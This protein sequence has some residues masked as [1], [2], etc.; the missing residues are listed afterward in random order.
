MQNPAPSGN[1]IKFRMPLRTS[2]CITGVAISC[3][4]LCFEIPM[5]VV[6]RV[7]N[8]KSQHLL[9]ACIPKFVVR[10]FFEMT[11]WLNLMT[12]SIWSRVFVRTMP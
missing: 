5:P 1:V 7:A 4:K 9:V 8:L 3:R 11:V 12:L 6:L 10:Y 2:D